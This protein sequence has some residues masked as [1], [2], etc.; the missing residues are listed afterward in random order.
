MTIS[1]PLD[2]PAHQF[3]SFSLTPECSGALLKSEFTYKQQMQ[4]YGGQ[5][6]V[7]DVTVRDLQEEVAREWVAFAASLS[8]SLG[9]FMLGDPIMSTPRGQVGIDTILVDG[10]GQTG[11]TI[12][13]KQFGPL[14]DN[15]LMKGDYLQIGLNLYVVLNDVGSDLAGE[16]T[17]D[18]FP[19]LRS[20]YADNTPVITSNPRGQFRAVSPIQWSCN[21]QKFYFFSFQAIEVI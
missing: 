12:S 6:W 7:A 10:G 18:I 5:A 1:F 20:S 21:E 13:L 11:Q 2:L 19:K 9:T 8:G 14:Q 17:V 3:T 16:L 15:A 4:D